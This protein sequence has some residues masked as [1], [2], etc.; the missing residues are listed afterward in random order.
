MS[1]DSST[2]R[3]ADHPGTGVR[4]PFT[5][6]DTP[7]WGI[8]SS[9]QVEYHQAM[10]TNSDSVRD[11]ERAIRRL[12]DAAHSAAEAG[13]SEREIYELVGLGLAD[14]QRHQDLFKP[15]DWATYCVM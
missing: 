4:S 12:R 15:V 2:F 3:S 5:S 13:V 7:M 11:R 14:H 10:T 8:P 1:S 6:N 9:R